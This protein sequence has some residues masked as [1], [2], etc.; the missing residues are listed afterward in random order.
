MSTS[1]S[2]V[3][4]ERHRFSKLDGVLGDP[5]IEMGKCGSFSVFR[6]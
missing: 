1:I 6:L 4:I 3:L 2:T 5:I